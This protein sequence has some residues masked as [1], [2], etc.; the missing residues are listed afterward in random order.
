MKTRSNLSFQ[1]EDIFQW[2]KIPISKTFKLFDE[3]F[4]Y[5]EL[6]Q[7]ILLCIYNTPIPAPRHLYKM[8]CIE[9]KK[10]LLKCGVYK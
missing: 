9:A 8:T 3:I 7:Y 10:I 6:I 2:E 4:F 5:F 1:K